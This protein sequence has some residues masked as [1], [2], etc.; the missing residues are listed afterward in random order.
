MLII[1]LET[2]NMP[3]SVIMSYMNPTPPNF[4]YI[5]PYWEEVYG[6]WNELLASRE[7]TSFFHI[8]L[9]LGQV[10]NYS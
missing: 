1:E 3:W 6:K 4:I 8:A 2:L 9:N 7:A 5:S 10:L